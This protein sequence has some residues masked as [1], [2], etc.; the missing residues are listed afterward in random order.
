[1]AFADLSFAGA[2]WHGRGLRWLVAPADLP[3]EFSLC[4]VP[5]AVAARNAPRASDRSLCAATRDTKS[6]QRLARM[7]CEQ[8]TPASG[9][10]RWSPLPHAALPEAWRSRLAATRPG[11]VAW[12]YWDLGQDL[13]GTRGNGRDGEGA[14]QTRA[15]RRDFLARLLHDLGHPAGTH[16]FW[17][18]CLPEM[19]EN[20]ASTGEVGMLFAPHPEAFWS[21]V[22]HL[23]CRA[24][25]VMGSAAVRAVGLPGTVRPFGQLR[26]RGQLVL[27]LREVESLAQDTS[28][29]G[30]TLAFLRQGLGPVA[31]LP[32]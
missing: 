18:A 4:A 3:P 2:L 13:T 25:I 20:A 21:G 15:T 26:W 28:R 1:M 12:T 17:P 19:A 24:V 10:A 30:P 23:G 6:E 14:V 29:Y 7:P 31:R 11:L 8:D 5:P 16:T 32:R 27:V 22:A 9:G